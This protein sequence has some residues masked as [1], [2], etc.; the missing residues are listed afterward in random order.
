MSPFHPVKFK[1]H[2]QDLYGAE[3][4]LSFLKISQPHKMFGAKLWW[5]IFYGAKSFFRSHRIINVNIY[6]LF[7]GSE[8][9]FLQ[10]TN[11][12]AGPQTL[13]NEEC[14]SIHLIV[15]VSVNQTKGMRS[16]FI[17]SLLMYWS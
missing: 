4:I 9:I 8:K 2:H 12:D 15:N 5:E 7:F 10:N 17:L 3:I 6:N 16:A 13:T 1:D 11:S 14:L